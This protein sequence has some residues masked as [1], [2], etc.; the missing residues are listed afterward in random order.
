MSVERLAYITGLR[1][2]STSSRAAE[3]TSGYIGF[4]NPGEND[5]EGKGGVNADITEGS[6]H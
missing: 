3:K 1:K 5:L 6:P 2:R 4:P